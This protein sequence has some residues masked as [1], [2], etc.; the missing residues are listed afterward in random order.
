[1]WD[2]NGKKY[3]QNIKQKLRK[4]HNTKLKQ[5]I[6]NERNRYLNQKS[7]EDIFVLLCL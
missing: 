7:L 3:D 2:F 5:Q 1:M 4:L 6:G